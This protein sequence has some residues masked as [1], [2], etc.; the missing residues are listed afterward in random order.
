MNEQ[1]Y[2][3]YPQGPSKQALPNSTAVLVLG[4]ISIAACWCYGIVGL[5]L[6][7]IS[8]V[9]S[10]RARKAYDENP[11]LYSLSSYKNMSAGRICAIIGTSLSALYLV[12]VI[13]YLIFL[14]VAIGSIWS[15]M[16]WDMYNY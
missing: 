10:S 3:A 2:Q 13:M 8:L 4:I 15:N 12:I 11:E 16:P 14:G 6:G 5:T 1:T 7:I 9:M